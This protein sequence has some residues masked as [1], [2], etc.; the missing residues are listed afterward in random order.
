MNMVQRKDRFHD[1]L[2][3]EDIKMLEP[4]KIILV[5][6]NR[7]YWLLSELK[8]SEKEKMAI[9]VLTKTINSRENE[10]RMYVPMKVEDVKICFNTCKELLPLN[11]FKSIESKH[12]QQRRRSITSKNNFQVS[13]T[14]SKNNFRVSN[15]GS[16]V[17]V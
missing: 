3:L 9:K 15:K 2:L 6:S 17:K 5:N 10:R 12:G 13:D 16:M 8:R 4:Q 14:T 11:T 1:F 7:L